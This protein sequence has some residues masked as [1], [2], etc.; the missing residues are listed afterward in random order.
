MSTLEGSLS[1]LKNQAILSYLFKGVAFTLILSVLAVGIGLLLGSVL[2]LVRNYCTTKKTIVFK[3]FAVTYI[4]IFRNTPLLLWIFV[5]L[6]F[7][8]F[9][10]ALS[11]K[12]FGLTSVEVKLLFKASAALILFTSSVI[13]EIV[14]GG[15]NSIAQ[16]QFEAGYS[17]G[18]NTVQVMI[19]I[20]LPQAYRNII[21]T[22][23]SQV[24]TTIKDSSYLANIAVIE[25]M[26]RVKTLLSSAYNYNGTGNVNVSDVF[27]LFGFAAILYFIINFS[28]S[29]VVRYMQKHPRTPVGTS[30]QS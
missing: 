8:P 13:A 30:G 29:S 2:A 10:E 15:L 9:P 22:L 19:Y 27:V 26:A 12:M 4:E 23:L 11:R 21:P 5:C 28:L 6:V 1:I 20:I 25:I 3:A 7:F 14:R 24:I 16:G 17:Q 18:F